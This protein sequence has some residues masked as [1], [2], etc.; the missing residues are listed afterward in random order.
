M[1]KIIC[2]LIFVTAMT[3]IASMAACSVYA[4]STSEVIAHVETNYI[5]ENG[6]VL[7]FKNAQHP[8]YLS[9]SIGLY[10]QYLLG[11]GDEARF[12]QQVN[13]L[14]ENFAHFSDENL[15]IKWEAGEAG[16]LEKI[17]TVGALIDDLRIAW[18]LNGA[19]KDFKEEYYAQISDKIISAIKETMIVNERL[20]DF[21]D[22]HYNLPYD[23]LF[24]SYFI[25]E[26]MEDFPAYVFE[27]LKDLYASPFFDEI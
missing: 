15:F 19:A 27:P 1:K 11:A 7:N 5:S 26:A 8:Q 10:M 4:K 17:T 2:L 18:V 14:L 13:V 6:L 22:W 16:N 9:E 25:I 24:M 12:R 23:Q 20:V 3:F 21:F